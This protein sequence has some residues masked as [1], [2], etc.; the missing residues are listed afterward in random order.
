M[1]KMPCPDFGFD[2][3]FDFGFGLG[4]LY[5]T[6][7]GPWKVDK[8]IGVEPATA[9]V[10]KAQRIPLLKQ[11]IDNKELAV[12]ENNLSQFSKRDLVRVLKN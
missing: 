7:K 5:P 10:R 3:E 6:W 2:L 4:R 1:A 9:M 12:V 8:V 11:T